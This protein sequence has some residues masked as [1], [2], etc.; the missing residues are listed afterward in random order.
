MS[1]LDAMAGGQRA[2]GRGRRAAVGGGVLDARSRPIYLPWW[3]LE[4]G[5]WACDGR[6]RVRVCVV[7]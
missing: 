6:V 4:G 3:R 2:A 5:G 7:G 1:F